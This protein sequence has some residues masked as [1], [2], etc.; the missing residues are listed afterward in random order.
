MLGENGI[1]LSGGQRQRIAIA[2]AL[3]KRPKL[4]ILDKATSSLDFETAEAF[5]KTI[6]QLKGKLTMLVIAHQL[7]RGL[8]V[9]AIVRLDGAIADAASA[10]PLE[11]VVA[12]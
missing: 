4:L 7:P 2:R 6:N 5:A 9:D 8:Q 10:A 11:P 1:G 3:L 12:A